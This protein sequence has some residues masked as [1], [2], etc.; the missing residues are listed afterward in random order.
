MSHYLQRVV[1]INVPLREEVSSIGHRASSYRLWVCVEEMG[2]G[3]GRRWSR[4]VFLLHNFAKRFCFSQ[5]Y[6][7]RGSG[8]VEHYLNKWQ[9][10][11]KRRVNDLEAE[12]CEEACTG[13]RVCHSVAEATIASIKIRSIVTFM[14]VLSCWRKIRK[15]FGSSI[16]R[17]PMW[18]IEA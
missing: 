3:F 7:V 6:C 10:S 1:L 15:E 11:G 13:F 16:L 8:T 5:P 9:R 18:I 2:W 4:K 14:V 12:R 17:R